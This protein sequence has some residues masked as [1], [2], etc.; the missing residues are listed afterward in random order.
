MGVCVFCT[1]DH[2][3]TNVRLMKMC[4]EMSVF[5]T[6]AGVKTLEK[7]LSLMGFKTVQP[8]SCLAFSTFE[9]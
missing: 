5:A 7:I 1:T 2:Y 9:E 8:G 3:L 6:V 4:I